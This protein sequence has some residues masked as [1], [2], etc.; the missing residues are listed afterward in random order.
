MRYHK[1]AMIV[2]PQPE[3]TE[4]GADILR[5]GRQ[6]GGRRHRLR[7]GAGRGRSADVRHR[8]LRQLRHLHAGQEVPRLHRRPRAGA[9]R[10]AARHV[11]QPDRARGARRLRLH[12]ARAGSTTSATSRSA[13]RPTSSMYYDAHREHGS[14]P[15][16]QHRRAR[17]PLGRERL[18]G[19][20]ARPLLV[21]GRRRHRPRAQPRAHRLHAGGAR[22]LLPAR[23][24]AQA[25]R[26]PRAS[27]ATTARPCALS[28]RA[29][30]TSSTRARS[31]TRSPRT[32]ADTRPALDR[33]SRRRGSTV[34]NAPL[35]GDYRG[36]RVS[37]NQPPG[38]G[39]MLLEML[40]ILEQLRPRR[41]RAQLGRVR[42]HR[43][44]AMKRA[45]IDKDRHVGDPQF[46]DV[47]VERLTSKDYA[48]RHGRA[49]SRAA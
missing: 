46:V 36:Y 18:D 27:I 40:N 12:P 26:R 20:A 32:C 22:A 3:P 28:P 30:P 21:G 7:A 11:G 25:G 42:A 38:G 43:G 1:R 15:W 6:R 39:V 2:A 35:W 10:R 9:A 16:E 29:A 24:H 41:A 4:A 13:R 14:L 34:R 31:P 48:R 8:R 37:T 5:D 33:G 23:R 17:H 47:P 45:T 49:R 44:E 19:A